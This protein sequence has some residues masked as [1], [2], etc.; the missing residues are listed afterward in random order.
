MPDSLI[1]EMKYTT[2]FEPDTVKIIVVNS[3]HHGKVWQHTHGFFEFVYVDSGFSLHSYNGKTSILTAGDLFAIFPGEVHSYSRAYHT[4]IYN[5]LFYLDELGSLRDEVLRLPSIDWERK[6]DTLPIIRVGLSERRELLEILEQMKTERR[7]KSDGWELTMKGLL[8]RFLVLY[9][10]LL[11]ESKRI[12]PSH[13]EPG[14]TRETDERGYHGY[15]YAALSF[16]EENYAR[17]ISCTD[18]AEAAGL[19][20][21][22]L[23]RQFKAVMSMTPAEYVRKFRI[24]KS[25]DLLRSTDA[26][27]ASIATEVGFGSISLYSRVFKQ[28]TGTSPATFRK[29]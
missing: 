27:I 6:N 22:Y 7:N 28:I 25:M 14:G 12:A 23:T 2:Y 4:T 26:S 8:L 5:C 15:I 18:I 10:R 24:A 19:S 1:P 9:S 11:T 17:D 13:S 21:D 3:Q 20:S 29:E 16:I